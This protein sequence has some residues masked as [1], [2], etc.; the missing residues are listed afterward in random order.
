[1]DELSRLRG[2]M[3]EETFKHHGFTDKM[4][5]N[6]LDEIHSGKSK[7]SYKMR[8]VIAP[9]MSAV[10]VLACLTFFVYLSGSQLDLFQEGKNASQAE[11]HELELEVDEN[12][13]K[14]NEDIK[15]P[16]L[17]P[18]EVVDRSYK[19][20]EEDGF[21]TFTV[22]LTGPQEQMLTV[23]MDL[24]LEMFEPEIDVPLKIG[25]VTGSYHYN[26][27]LQTSSVNWFDDGIKYYMQFNPRTSNITL[28]KEDMKRIA[29]S[30]EK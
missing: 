25:E 4:R 30:I 29:E 11:W 7:S 9:I 3:K 6:I 23:K 5:R 27:E 15:L 17:V 24:G 16:S 19:A 10:F 26:R 22:K 1:M 14:W 2:L 18:F 8:P 20:T 12:D 28:D 13:T 21:D